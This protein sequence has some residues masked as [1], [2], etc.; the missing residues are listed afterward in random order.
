MSPDL[1]FVTGG[2]SHL[3]NRRP[4]HSAVSGAKNKNTSQPQATKAAGRKSAKK[5][6]GRT[7]HY[8]PAPEPLSQSSFR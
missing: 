2:D 6:K 7:V 1:V 5:K 3:D 4:Q 8:T